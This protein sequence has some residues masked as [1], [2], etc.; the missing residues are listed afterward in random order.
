MPCFLTISQ[1]VNSWADN[2]LEPESLDKYQPDSQK[3]AKSVQQSSKLAFSPARLLSLRWL[4]QAGAL[5]VEKY[6]KL[7][8]SSVLQLGYSIMLPHILVRL[9]NVD[10]QIGRVLL[11]ATMSQVDGTLGPEIASHTGGRCHQLTGWRKVL[12]I[13][14]SQI[15]WNKI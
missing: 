2:F 6:L 14:F 3:Y 8:D 7:T 15:K 10:Q 4:R 5:V 13:N 12:I 1:Q 11:P 9:S